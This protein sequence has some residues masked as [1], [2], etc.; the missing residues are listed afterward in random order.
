MFD[1][2]IAMDAFKNAKLNLL[3]LEEVTLNKGFSSY[4][5]KNKKTRATLNDEH[6]I[7]Q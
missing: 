7:L 6:S 5:L 2:E 1:L 3:F 4:H